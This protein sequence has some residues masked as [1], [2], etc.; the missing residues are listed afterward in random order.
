[1]K[2]QVPT[3]LAILVCASAACGQLM[4]PT[5]NPDPADA[6]LQEII[7]VRP[8]EPD[9]SKI[10]D[11]AY[12]ESYRKLAQEAALKQAD[13]V[14][15]FYEK[16]PRHEKAMPAMLSRWQILIRLDKPA[17]VFEETEKFL[18]DNPASPYRPEATYMRAMSQILAPNPSFDKIEPLVEDFI[19]SAPNE[20]EPASDLLYQLGEIAPTP[21]KQIAIYKRVMT[22]Y[23]KTSSA[24]QAEASIKRAE[25]LGKPF[26]LA[27]TDAINGKSISMK[28]FKGKVVVIDF[29]ATW[30]G[31]CIA[32]MP[33]LKALYAKYKD[34]GVEFI[35]VSLD[36]PEKEGGL[37]ELKT[38]VEQN[39]IEWPQYY[40]GNG[41]ESAFS[42]GWGITSIPHMFIVDA[43]GN[44]HSA[45]ADANI[46]TFITDLIA[47]RD[48]KTAG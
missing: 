39:K 18:A 17:V 14:K 48:K 47:K 37:K 10:D 42:S 40:Q 5:T 35:G 19:K 15:A 9:E 26:E 20:R 1:M 13:M 29:W 11:P 12:V 45:N 2:F 33:E 32:N 34:K 27:F 22:Q 4:P 25:K 41:W 16:F 43:D 6:M 24:Q 8:P 38:Y 7:A 21:E 30:C 44:L 46:E 23:P 28:D 31:P 36:H 3:L